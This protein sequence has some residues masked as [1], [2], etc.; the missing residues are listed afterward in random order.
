MDHSEAVRTKAAERYLLGEMSDRARE[1][2]EEHF[3]GCTECARDVQAGAV[4][5]DTAR[6]LLGPESAS[7]APNA[8]GV[9]GRRWSWLLRPAFAI[10]AMAMLFLLVGYQNV[11]MIPHMKSELAHANTPQIEPVFS[12]LGANSRGGATPEITVPR[13][14]PFGVF[15]D[16]PPSSQFS[17]Y[18]CEVRTDSGDL[19]FWMNVSLDEAKS[20]VQLMIP[21]SQLTPGKYVLVVRGYTSPET[22]NT[23]EVAR[24][25]FILKSSN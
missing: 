6:D 15:V 3:F 7:L 1:E 12:L 4:F 24:Y 14:K 2:Y 22:G 9:R 25:P 18:I 16:I 8:E 5:V 20:T 23:A 11:Y 17:R 21:P 10:P 19:K 13:D